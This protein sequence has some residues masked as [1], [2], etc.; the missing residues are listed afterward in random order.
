MLDIRRLFAP[1]AWFQVGKT[2]AAW[3]RKLNEL[4]DTETVYRLQ[5]TYH[6]SPHIARIGDSQ[7]V[8]ISNFPYHYGA[9]YNLEAMSTKNILPKLATRERLLRRVEEA[10]NIV[11]ARGVIF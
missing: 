1:G 4:L 10:T 9:P 2:N 6:I 7:L 8:W 5:Y 3:D 11:E